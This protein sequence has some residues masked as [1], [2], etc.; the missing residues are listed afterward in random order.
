MNDFKNYDGVV[1]LFRSV[2]CIGKENCF[3]V[4]FKNN[5]REGLKYGALGAIGGAVGAGIAA[6]VSSFSSGVLQGIEAYEGLL[7]NQTEMGLGIIPLSQNGVQMFL[8]VDKLEAH[9][10]RFVFIPNQYIE[11]IVVKNFNIFNKKMQ[12]VNIKLTDGYTFYQVARLKEKNVN[13]QES[14]FGRFVSRYK[15]K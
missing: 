5:N 6:A 10:E 11:S 2:N 15:K 9:P 7:F 12:K 1:N 13:Y 3:F 14:E 8:N 4:T